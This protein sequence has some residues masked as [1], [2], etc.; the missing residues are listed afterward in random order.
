MR[1]EIFTPASEQPRIC[2]GNIEKGKLLFPAKQ[3][4]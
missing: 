1:V 4:K 3:V 2:A